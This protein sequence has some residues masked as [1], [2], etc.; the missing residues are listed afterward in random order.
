MVNLFIGICIGIVF[1]KSAYW[2]QCWMSRYKEP[3]K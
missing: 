1:V 2:I 3:Q